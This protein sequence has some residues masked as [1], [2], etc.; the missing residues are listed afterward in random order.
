MK[1]A[2]A[3]PSFGGGR[4]A[5]EWGTAAAWVALILAVLWVVMG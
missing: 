2:T 3:W 4:R 5:R 1:Y